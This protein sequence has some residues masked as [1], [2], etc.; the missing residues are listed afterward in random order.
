MV[1]LLRQDWVA[2]L[3]VKYDV[4]VVARGYPQ[5]AIE[6]GFQDFYLLQL[7][8]WISC[9]LFIFF[10]T[11]RKDFVEM[12]VHHC[13]TVFLI[14]F[15]Y[16]FDFSRPGILVMSLHDLGDVFLYAAKSAQY[17]GKRALAD[18]LFGLFAISFYLARL[19]FLP[20]AL[21]YPL[22]SSIW[23]GNS[24]PAMRVIINY[25]QG[26][27]LTWMVAGLGLLVCLHCMWGTTIARM[28]VRTVYAADKKTVTENGD[29]RS[30]A[31]DSD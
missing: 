10:E 23:Q 5:S 20:C 19:V 28:V 8:F 13:S 7:G 26:M 22:A 9:C 14:S 17:R 12:S 24:S 4:F 15:S 1:H 6:M 29:P 21:V 16:L 18:L 25:G 27:T 11:R 3:F 31:E 2:D 30:G